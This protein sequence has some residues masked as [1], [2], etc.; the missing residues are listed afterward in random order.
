MRVLVYISAITSAPPA[1][2]AGFGLSVL[3][4][5]P[6]FYGYEHFHAAVRQPIAFNH[7][8]HVANGIACTDCHTGVETQARATLPELDT[9]MNCHQAALTDS[10][11][12]AR[13]RDIA[14][15]GKPIA[16]QRLTQM[17]PHVFFSHRRHVAGA[18]LACAECHGAMEKATSPP[19]RALRTLTMDT[20]LNCH[21]S[22]GVDADCNDC[23]R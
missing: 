23:H 21:K 6:A 22:K 20:C 3:L 16:W 17:P 7:A 11:E 13:L 2:I 8:K 14:A 15:S 18:K 5:V 9:C 1:A 10:R 12:E 19:P 4:M